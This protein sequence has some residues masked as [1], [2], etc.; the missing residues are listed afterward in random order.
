MKISVQDL[1]KL[2]F[3]N[4]YFNLYISLGVIEH[5]YNG[6]NDVIKEANRVVTNGGYLII[7][8]PQISLLRRIKI[9]LNFYKKS[10]SFTRKGFYQF[11]FNPKHILFD[12]KKYGL[13][14]ISKRSR[15]GLKG[16]KD[17]IF[18]LKPILQFLFNYKGRNFFIRSIRRVLDIILAPFSGHMCELILQK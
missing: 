11:A 1:R 15:N 4:G 12:M 9:L 10:D 13:K 5:F 7:T 14:K 16:L 3:K 17:E 8:F 2:S 6:Y 18:F